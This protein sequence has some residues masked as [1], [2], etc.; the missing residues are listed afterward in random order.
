[1]K[2]KNLLCAL[3]LT[4]CFVGCS[5]NDDPTPPDNMP[6]RTVLVY[7][8]AS[9][10]DRDLSLTKNINA[11][12]SVATPENLN[13]G[14]L[15]VFYSD[16]SKNEAEL[17]QIEEGQNGQITRHHIDSYDGQSAI[18]PATMTQVIKDVISKF[19]AESYGLTFSSHGNAWLPFNETNMLRSFGEENGK[20]MDIDK[21]ASALAQTNINFDFI[22]F[23]ACSMGAIE[24][25]YELKD[26]TDYIVSSPSEILTKGFPYETILPFL[27]TDTPRLDKVAQ[28]FYSSYNES[29]DPYAN[30]SVVK[31]DELDELA[32]IVKNI[33]NISGGIETIFDLPLDNIQIISNL[34]P[35]SFY[36]YDFEDFFNH[37]TTDNKLQSELKV[38]LNKTITDKYTTN[39]TYFGSYFRSYPINKFSG[40]SIYSPQRNLTQLNDWYKQHLKWY[41]AVYN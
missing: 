19:P 31:T 10:L 3:L 26:V 32:I 21:L 17:F 16:L 29:K 18:D 5:D 2:I 6:K 8:V 4:V 7:M 20:W 11:M 38:S 35:A 41:N 27:F 34:S 24:C 22:L 14:N 36:L 23:D 37:L 30:I 15:I 25:V 39:E 9:N 12:I 33:I 13:G 40:L 28:L 1:M